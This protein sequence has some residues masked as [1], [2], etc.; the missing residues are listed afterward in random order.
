MSTRLALTI[1]SMGNQLMVS[2]AE[3]D[4]H[5][6]SVYR[7]TWPIT[8]TESCNWGAWATHRVRKGDG[9][10]ALNADG[11]SIYMPV[12]KVIQEH[13]NT[14]LLH[15]SDRSDPQRFDEYV[16]LAENFHKA[17]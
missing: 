9:A 4:D 14:S 11:W 5:C 2:L 6:R 15:L 7:L 3:L 17:S 10:V 1:W 8:Y 13:C 16:E 12:E